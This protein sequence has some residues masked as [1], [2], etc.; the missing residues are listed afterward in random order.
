M[1]RYSA[2][3]AKSYFNLLHSGFQFSSLICT[4]LYGSSAFL[5]THLPTSRLL[6][7]SSMAIVSC[8][9]CIFGCILIYG[10]F[11]VSF[12]QNLALGTYLPVR[13]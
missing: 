11:S 2:S 12:V 10:A 13:T 3:G 8:V 5:A 9:Q 4:F 7:Y 1:S 6:F